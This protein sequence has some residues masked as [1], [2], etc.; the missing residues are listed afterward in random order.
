MFTLPAFLLNLASTSAFQLVHGVPSSIR[1]IVPELLVQ[2]KMI[3]QDRADTEKEVYLE[4]HIWGKLGFD[5]VWEDMDFE[6]VEE[7]EEA[8]AN[9]LDVA[10]DDV[11]EGVE[12]AGNALQ[13]MSNLLRRCGGT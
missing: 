8:E 3:S 11:G 5:D 2:G 10:G 12:G 4:S 1:K 9:G 13:G 6:E 7:V